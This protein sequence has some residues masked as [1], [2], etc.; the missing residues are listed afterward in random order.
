MVGRTEFLGCFIRFLTAMILMKLILTFFVHV[1]YNLQSVWGQK[2]RM[3]GSRREAGYLIGSGK[4]NRLHH[5]WHIER[6]HIALK[7]EKDKWNLQELQIE[8]KKINTKIWLH[9]RISLHC[10][11]SYLLLFF[12]F[13]TINLWKS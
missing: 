4:G 5:A 2:K 10:Q 1:K 6:R 8:I 9:T 7:V 3:D 12:K 13:L 11:K